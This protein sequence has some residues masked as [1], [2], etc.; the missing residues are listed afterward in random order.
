LIK[1]N[2]KS[3]MDLKVGDEVRCNLYKKLANEVFI[4]ESITPNENCHS[5]FMVVAH[6]KSDP[7]KR[8][9]GLKKDGYDFVDGID[10]SWFEKI[11]SNE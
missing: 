1:Q 2:L 9:V 7:S 6:L 3:K 8:I 4:V 5:K 10:S 11:T